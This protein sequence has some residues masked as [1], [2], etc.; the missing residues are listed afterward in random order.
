MATA[1]PSSTSPSTSSA[2]T[3]TPSN[4]ERAERVRGD[5]VEALTG[6]P[7]RVTGDDERGHAPARAP[8]V[9]RAKTV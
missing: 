8:G 3:R 7:G 1:K 4:S 6:Q 9:V 5:H 2:V